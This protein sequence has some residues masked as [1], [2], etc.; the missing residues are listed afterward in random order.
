MFNGGWRMVNWGQGMGK[1]E[2]GIGIGNGE[3]GMSN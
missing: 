1:G 2:W 3:W